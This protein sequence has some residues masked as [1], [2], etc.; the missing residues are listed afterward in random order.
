MAE[1]LFANSNY[2]KILAID[3]PKTR[4][5]MHLDTVF[6][7]IDYDK[8]IVHPLI[9]DNIDAFKLHEITREGIKDINKG[10]IDVLGELTGKKVTLIKCGGEDPIAAG[11][12]Q[13]NDGTNVLTIAPGKVIAY[14]RNWVTIDLLKKQELKYY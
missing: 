5:F 12:E 7:N 1:R 2:Q 13:W 8:F 11:R 14:D 4:S 10:L 6:T 9:F 3:L